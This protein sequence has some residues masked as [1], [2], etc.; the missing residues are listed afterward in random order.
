MNLEKGLRRVV[1]TVSLAAAGASLVVTGYD[2]YKTTRYVLATNEF[3]ACSEETEQWTP[4]VEEFKML[5]DA[6]RPVA[7]VEAKIGDVEMG[8]RSGPPDEKMSDAERSRWTQAARN[9]RS[10]RCGD[11]RVSLPAHLDRA[12]KLWY[13]T[14]WLPLWATSP[15]NQSYSLALLPLIWGVLISTGLGALPWC[16]FYIARWIVQGFSD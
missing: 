11:I 5:P 1:L 4:T 8:P 9:Y 13:G 16:M 3:V 12:M 14:S 6:A 2:T 15:S 7:T 10:M